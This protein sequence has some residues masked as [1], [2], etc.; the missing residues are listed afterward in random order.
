MT[1]KF[2]DVV[3]VSPQA[4]VFKGK[5]TTVTVPGT[6]GTFQI[7]FDHAPIFSTTE[8]GEVVVKD[9]KDTNEYF[10]VSKGF[11]EVS[12]N[13]VS[14]VVEVAVKSSEISLDET[15][16]NLTKLNS[17]LTTADKSVKENLK[18]QI[19]FEEA[20]LKVVSYKN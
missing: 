19:K 4:I 14:I 1:E 9:E 7:L 13:N 5:A 18:N 2:F 11:V 6:K 3:I 12:A 10:A 17:E 16:Q 15:N 8:I 20:K